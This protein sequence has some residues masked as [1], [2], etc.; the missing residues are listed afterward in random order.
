MEMNSKLVYTGDHFS[1]HNPALDSGEQIILKTAKITS[2]S[3]VKQ[4]K[5]ENEGSFAGEKIEGFRRVFSFEKKQSEI[6]LKLDHVSGISLREFCE[7]K[8]TLLEKVH[9]CIRLARALSSVHSQQIIHLNLNP[10]HILIES[11]TG[12]IY[13]ISLGIATRLK[14]KIGI[15]NKIYFS[16]ANLDFIAPEQTGRISSDVGYFSDIYSLGGVFY[17]LFTNQLMFGSKEYSA[18]IHAHIALSPVAPRDISDTPPLISNLIMKMVEKDIED[19]YQSIFGVLHDLQVIFSNLENKGVIKNFELGSNDSSGILQ[20]SNQLYGRRKEIA[21]LNDNYERVKNGENILVLIYGNSGVGKSTLAEQLYRPVLQDGGFYITGKF[22][23]L[24]ADVP[25]FAFSQA[26][27]SWME[28]ILLEDESTLQRWKSE[29]TKKLHPI[30]RALFDIVPNLDKLLENEPVLPVLHGQESKLRFEYALTNFVKVISESGKPMVI[31]IDDLQW[32]DSSSLDLIKIILTNKDLKNF[33]LIGTYR[34]N[35]IF[36]GH[37]FME[38]K[39]ELE[40]YGIFPEAIHLENLQSK[41]IHK[42]VS[43]TLGNSIS[44]LKDLA[45]IIQKKSAG[46]AL[47]VNQFIKAIYSNE[48]LTFD[49]TE[50]GWKWDTEKLLEFNVE[51][52]IV[53]LLIGTIQKLP[54][55]TIS[56]LK[57]ASCIGNK[58]NLDILSIVT[59]NLKDEVYEKLKP[60]INSGMILEGRNKSLYFVHDKVQQAIY[61]LNEEAAKKEIHLKIGRLLLEKTPNSDIRENIFDIVHHFNFAKEWVKEKAEIKKVSDLNLIAGIRSQNAAA[62]SMALHYFENAI[63]FLAEENWEKDNEFVLRVFFKAAEAAYQSNNQAQFEKFAG[64]LDVRVNKKV[65][66]LKLAVLKIKNANI[67]NDQK[68]VINIGLEAVKLLGYKHKKNPSKI[69]FL[70]GYFLTNYR[71]SKITL[72]K[73][74]KLPKSTNEEMI[75]GIEI[76]Q[77]VAFASYFLSPISV[78]LH[79]FKMF[80]WTLK[81]GIAPQSTFTIL[82]FG[83]INIV[84]MNNIKKGLKIAQLGYELSEYLKEDE[85]GCKV[86]GAYHIFISFWLKPMHETIP[87]LEDSF[88]RGL[89]TGEFEYNSLTALMI[90]FNRFFSG[91]PLQNITKRGE[92]LIKQ[93]TPLNQTLQIARVRMFTQVA[94]LLIQG[95]P[96]DYKIQGDIL[97][98]EEVSF[99]DGPVSSSYYSN[100]FELKKVVALIFNQYELAYDF[101]IKQKPYLMSINGTMGEYLY[102]FYENLCISSI[103]DSRTDKEQKRLKKTLKKNLDKYIKYVGFSEANFLHR[104]ELM[105]AEI[106][107]LE[108]N[109]DLAAKHYFNSIRYA[110]INKFIQEEAIAWERTG[111]LYLEMNQAEVA[112]F[113]LSNAYKTYSKW[114]AK[115]KLE[116]MK[117]K[118]A[119]HISPEEIGVNANS[120]DL[121]TILKTINLLSG[122]VV[123]ENILVGLMNLVAEN[124]GAE[125]AFLISLENNKKVIKASIEKS[126]NQ[127][128]VMQD[129]PFEEFEEISSSVVNSVARNGEILV[130]DDANLVLPYSNDDY[131]F[132]NAIRSI[133]CIPLKHGNTILAFLY[134]ENRLLSGAFSKERLEILHILATQTSIS[135]QNAMLFDQTNRLNL[136]LK[137]EVDMRK[138][139]EEN[140]RI[141]EKRL[142]EY[143]INLENK[144]NERTLDLKIE[145]E[146]SDELLLNILPYDIAMELKEKGSADAKKF[147]NVTVLFTDFEGFSQIAEEMNAVDLVSEIDYCFKEFD[148]IIQKHNIEKIKTIGDAYMAV[149]G[150][151]VTNETHPFDVVNAAIEIMEF[152]KGHKKR[153]LA[154]NQPVFEIRIGIHSGNVVAGI[155]GFKKFAYD[156]WGDTVNVASRMESSGE[157][158]KIN[159][160]GTTYGLIKEKYKCSYRGKIQA[161]NK[162]EIDMYFVDGKVD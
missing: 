30:G 37:P 28:Q 79:I 50:R 137:Q 105:K 122:E 100:L 11:H 134:L 110:R 103:Y 40:N 121:N 3:P 36:A 6:I 116:Q 97:D 111:I 156:I 117:E 69:D 128:N 44:P 8:L 62:Y 61:S 95:F 108:K 101:S 67:K 7:S 56:M 112:Q 68:L 23:H 80:D 77:Y 96:E 32:S 54:Q 58:F 148:K 98:E 85:N 72:D 16:D 139:I 144:V 76:L 73:V 74:S 25:Y 141:N 41:D 132:K 158:G 91:D 123:L 64:I 107:L 35:E 47:F 145:K 120:L 109:Y 146:K 92:L 138:V 126:T 1:I 136:E 19:R 89:N 142:E 86:R 153:K 131:I 155:V 114:G 2:L 162:G 14:R 31:F 13:F 129:I 42:L 5:A 87:D 88:K 157:I 59:G 75:L 18:K 34:D 22:D 104:L 33:L 147:E 48:I 24:K 149:G 29:L 150:L 143:N 152:M 135:L 130:L 71:L 39:T 133:V 49:R 63:E 161:K 66:K 160:S 140:L 113:Y 115:A 15:D 21:K 53:D 45:D 9:L 70:V 106:F 46:N 124:A 17:W 82:I 51:G 118:Y 102:Y 119:G 20:F 65:E 52:D 55:E 10:D 4:M 90:M 151:P 12:S 78:P 99:P 83:Y 93:M 38:F 26:F 154:E 84:H 57:L 127:I 125:R 81:Y 27:G 43:D 60:A 94:H 159:I